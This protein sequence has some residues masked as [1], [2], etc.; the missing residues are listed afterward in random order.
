MPRMNEESGLWR[1]T[2][3][4][5]AVANSKIP[6]EYCPVYWSFGHW[7]IWSLIGIWCLEFGY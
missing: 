4:E 2:S 7:I 3:E 5:S 1:T 6:N